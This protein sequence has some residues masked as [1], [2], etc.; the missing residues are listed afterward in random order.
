[1]RFMMLVKADDKA[2][3]GVMPGE[4][5]LSDMDKFNQEMIKAG[6]MLAGEG[7]H[8]TSK[9]VRLRCANGKVTMEKGPFSGPKK[10]LVSGFWLIQAPSKAEAIEWAK[11]VPFEDGEIEVRQI[12]EL[13][14]FPVNAAEQPDGWREKEQRFRDTQAAKVDLTAAP[15]KIRFVSLVKAD[16]NTEEGVPPDEKLLEAMGK[17]ME[18]MVKGGVMLAAEGLQP[19]AKGARITFSGNKRT[20]VDGPFAEAKEL[21]AGFS[22][23][24]VSSLEEAIEWSRRFVQVD[25]PGRLGAESTLEVRR[26]QEVSDFAPNT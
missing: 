25:A 1:M 8:P 13:E 18:D 9:G 4:K 12:F 23:F 14:D 10:N 20:V 22:V 26:L 3:A 17:L 15:G 19:S 6:V 11:R 5:L 7:L 16:A 21:V 2:E 24:Q